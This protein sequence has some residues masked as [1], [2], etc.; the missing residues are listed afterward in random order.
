VTSRCDV[1][2]IP[3]NSLF[4]HG[5]STTSSGCSERK[6][7]Q[8]G[9]SSTQVCGFRARQASTRERCL[10]IRELSP[11]GS[12][13][14]LVVQQVQ[15]SKFFPAIDATFAPYQLSSMFRSRQSA[16]ARSTF[17]QAF[18]AAAL[19]FRPTRA[20]MRRSTELPRTLSRAQRPAATFT[21]TNSLVS[22]HRTSRV[23][24]NRKYRSAL[25]RTKRKSASNPATLATTYTADHSEAKANIEVSPF[26]LF[27]AGRW[28][29]LWPPSAERDHYL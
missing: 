11:P 7:W 6:V 5:R 19:T 20:T 22:G 18:L 27:P 1:V 4:G 10:A 15:L 8:C 23:P 21:A 16:G 13:S 24:R 2:S 14:G 29:F 12:E 3:P 17:P 9:S 25:R 28:P 26:G